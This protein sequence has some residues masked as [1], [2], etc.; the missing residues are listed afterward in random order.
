MKIKEI[1]EIARRCCYEYRLIL[2]DA[3]K[4]DT[5]ITGFNDAAEWLANSIWRDR[6]ETPKNLGKR[7]IIL[8]FRDDSYNIILKGSYNWNDILEI[9]NFI[10]W[11]YI[12]DLLPDKELLWHDRLFEGSVRLYI[13]R[14]IRKENDGKIKL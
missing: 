8:M 5:Y 10:K 1:D 14:P 7:E 4:A 12:D 11:A 13:I 3:Q 2:G 6:D 9:H